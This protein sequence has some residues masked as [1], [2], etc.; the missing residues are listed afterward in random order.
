MEKTLKEL[1]ELVGGE[2][3]GNGDTLIK[4]VAPLDSAVHGDITFVLSSRYAGS[5]ATTTASAVIV[6][7]DI[8]VA[9]KNL[10]ITQNPQLAYAKILTVF[11]SRPYKGS[12]VDK[13]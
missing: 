4:G 6:P 1:A 12:G 2:V 8:K 13:R 7:P 3:A 10:I 11:A 5:L 9:D